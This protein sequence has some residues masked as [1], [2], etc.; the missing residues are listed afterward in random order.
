MEL[1]SG[2]S[3]EGNILFVEDGRNS[4]IRFVSGTMVRHAF[5]A[6]LHRSAC[7]G[8]I[9]GGEAVLEISG[10][11]RLLR[12][13]DRYAI[14]AMRS[15]AL[16]PIGGGWF[17]HRVFG[18]DPGRCRE[19][20]RR[21][22]HVIGTELPG[23]WPDGFADAERAA[24][25]IPSAF[26]EILAVFENEP[27]REWRLQELASQFGMQP[28]S[29][30]RAFSREVG[31]PVTQYLLL[32][33][34]WKKAKE[35]QPYDYAIH[36]IYWLT[37]RGQYDVTPDTAAW[38]AAATLAVHAMTEAIHKANQ[39]TIASGTPWTK[40]QQAAIAQANAILEAAGIWSRRG[41]TTA[42]AHDVAQAGI[43]AVKQWASQ[44]KNA[45]VKPRTLN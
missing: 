37:L 12:A 14:P 30:S 13:G 2:N 45:G 29:F 4:G 11:E 24:S 39:L 5:P 19:I 18:T 31:M 17:S 15:H 3:D 44:P 23:E 1:R 35:D 41:W 10:G 8:V 33:K 36:L 26:R 43:D 28:A 38:V 32:A 16:R 6:H 9:A 22:R 27:E 20:A 21:L 42:A 7:F 34:V 25:A 40:K